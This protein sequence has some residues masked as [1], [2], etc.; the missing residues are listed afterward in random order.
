M[1]GEK[2][3]LEAELAAEKAKVEE[4]TAQ[5]AVLGGSSA[6]AEEDDEEEPAYE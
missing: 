6:A 1:I 2:Q 4:L 5:L 3:R